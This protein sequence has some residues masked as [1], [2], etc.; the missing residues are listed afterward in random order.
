MTENI[1]GMVSSL[2]DIATRR[3]EG[4]S[5]EWATFFSTYNQLAQIKK[6][7]NVDMETFMAIEDCFEDPAVTKITMALYNWVVSDDEVTKSE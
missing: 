5:E 6:D 2:I 7:P 4:S 1:E 3:P